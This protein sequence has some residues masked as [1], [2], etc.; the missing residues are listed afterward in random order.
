[1]TPEEIRI[2]VAE[3]FWAKVEKSEACWNWK[4]SK[5]KKGYGNFVHKSFPTILAHR[6]SWILSNGAIPAM[7][8]V[9]HHCDNPSCVRPD[10][11]FIGTRSDNMQ[12][13]VN[14]GRHKGTQYLRAGRSNRKYAVGSKNRTSK[15]TEEQAIRAKQCSRKRGEATRLAK[16]FGVSLS[17]I[18]DIRDGKRWVHL[19][20][21][22]GKSNL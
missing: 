13:C 11:L 22:N 8:D 9:C 2:A 14:K 3:R 18:C 17:I 7:L 6:I 5:S 10:H 19:S 20:V 12:D 21:A 4:A 15:L 16:E 1:M